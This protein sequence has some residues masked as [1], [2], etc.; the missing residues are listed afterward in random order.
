M[1]DANARRYGSQSP[2]SGAFG[3]SVGLAAEDGAGVGR[4]WV[5]IG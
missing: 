4:A 2:P 5:K 3:A 1:I